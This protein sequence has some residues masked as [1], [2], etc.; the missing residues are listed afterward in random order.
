MDVAGVQ[1]REPAKGDY[2]DRMMAEYGPMPTLPE[3][4]I[5]CSALPPATVSYDNVLPKSAL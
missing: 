2:W 3:A 5:D 1:S 4:G